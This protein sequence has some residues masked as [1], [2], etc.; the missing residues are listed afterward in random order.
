[1]IKL[2]ASN[3]SKITK[4]KNY[5]SVPRLEINEEVVHCNVVNNGYK[6][7]SRL[8]LLYTFSPNK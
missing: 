3:Q 4:D 1:M 7:G 5:K 8:L 2:L 6:H